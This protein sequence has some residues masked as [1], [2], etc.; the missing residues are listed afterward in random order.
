M[1]GT[2]WSGIRM[3]TSFMWLSM[4]VEESLFHNSSAHRWKFQGAV[5]SRSLQR[6][7]LWLLPKTITMSWFSILSTCLN[8]QT[9]PNKEIWELEKKTRNIGDDT[10]CYYISL[11]SQSHYT[12]YTTRIPQIFWLKKA[13]NA[14]LIYLKKENAH[15]HCDVLLS[16]R[17]VSSTYVFLSQLNK[18]PV[19]YDNAKKLTKTHM[20]TQKNTIINGCKWC[21]SSDYFAPMWDIEGILYRVPCFF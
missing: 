5:V 15:Q 17:L 3:V 20:H 4:I 6:V 12:N 11:W 9:N 1:L 21:F 18:K 13:R 10:L 7:T 8:A 2:F 19:K 14:S 16:S